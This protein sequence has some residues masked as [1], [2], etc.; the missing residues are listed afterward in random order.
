M[1]FGAGAAMPPQA[2]FPLLRLRLRDFAHLCRFVRLLFV[3]RSVLGRQL[4]MGPQLL[5]G[6]PRHV[7]RLRRP[8]LRA[9]RSPRPRVHRIAYRP[10]FATSRTT[11][12]SVR[13]RDVFSPAHF[14]C[15]RLKCAVEESGFRLHTFCVFVGSVKLALA[16]IGK[17]YYNHGVSA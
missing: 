9:V 10:R 16:Y 5:F 12:Q 14:P 17:K 6:L 15:F 7:Q 11:I 1:K 4:R 3:I 8:L 13:G 2:S